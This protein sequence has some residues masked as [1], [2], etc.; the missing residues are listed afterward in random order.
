MFPG[1]AADF[2]DLWRCFEEV[3]AHG[4]FTDV[5]KVEWKEWFQIVFSSKCKRFLFDIGEEGEEG[6]VLQ[7]STKYFKSRICPVAEERK[8]FS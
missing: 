3:A 4:K 1:S 2:C 5:V 8:D 7:R 6:R